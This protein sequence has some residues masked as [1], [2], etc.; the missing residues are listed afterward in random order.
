MQD[1]PSCQCEIWMERYQN[2]S[3]FVWNRFCLV[4]IFFSRLSSDSF[5]ARIE[6]HVCTVCK[7][8][9]ELDLCR[10][11]HM[12]KI[13]RR[14]KILS[15]WINGP[16]SSNI[17]P[18]R[19]RYTRWILKCLSCIVLALEW[20]LLPTMDACLVSLVGKVNESFDLLWLFSLG[21]SQSHI[22]VYLC[23]MEQDIRGSR[24]N[25]PISYDVLST[26]LKDRL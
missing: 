17:W 22:I 19:R 24:S 11:S 6:V 7:M 9:L 13:W 10:E 2:V 26:D 14:F 4:L 16:E 23:G 3:G 25:I 1:I 15:G 12:C 20:Q 18:A 5:T 21:P 8:L